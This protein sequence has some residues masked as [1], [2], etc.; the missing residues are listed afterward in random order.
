MPV[1]KS[2][3]VSLAR[4]LQVWFSLSIQSFG[5]GVATLALIRNAAVDQERWVTDLEFTRLWSISQIAPGINL[6]ALTIL[7]G[8]KIGGLA[9]IAAALTGLLVP[10]VT[11]TILMTAAY[12]GVRQ[13]PSMQAA[14]HGVLPATI[15]LGMLAAFQMARPLAA[16]ARKEGAVS[17]AVSLAVVLGSASAVAIR[18]LPV[19]A[20]LLGAGLISAVHAWLKSRYPG[21][22]EGE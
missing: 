14:L 21:R 13:A 22:K 7:I 20:V 6:F 18:H 10:S 15:G 5:G 12:A 17:T 2:G 19:V 3:K 16:A 4:I 9:G 11:V 8:K 1:Q